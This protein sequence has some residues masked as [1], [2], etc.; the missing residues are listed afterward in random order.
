[1][2]L[3]LGRL[4]QCFKLLCQG[5]G[6]MKA[7]HELDEMHGFRVNKPLC[8]GRFVLASVGR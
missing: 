3:K 2:K 4:K 7:V 1:M 6:G 8:N 5:F